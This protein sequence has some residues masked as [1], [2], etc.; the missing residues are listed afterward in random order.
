MNSTIHKYKSC[1]SSGI[2]FK[3]LGWPTNLGK[4]EIATIINSNLLV[5]ILT[6]YITF[7]ISIF[8]EMLEGFCFSLLCSFLIRNI[9]SV[10][11]IS[12]IY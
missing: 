10:K 12:D 3:A 11:K 5:L 1:W 4:K 6:Y 2:R 9:I 7:F 8:L